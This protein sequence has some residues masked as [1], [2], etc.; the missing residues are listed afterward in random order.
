[1]A[2]DALLKLRDLLIGFGEV[3][4]LVEHGGG[5]WEGSILFAH[6]ELLALVFVA[7]ARCRDI[8]RGVAEATR[9]KNEASRPCS[10]RVLARPGE[11]RH[12]AG[13][14]KGPLAGEPRG[15]SLSPTFPTR[16]VA[17]PILLG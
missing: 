10:S 8:R 17:R 6:H 14:S 15:R 5:S 7:P 1:M 9:V 2:S 11:D 4:S 13:K 3:F 16:T 12:A